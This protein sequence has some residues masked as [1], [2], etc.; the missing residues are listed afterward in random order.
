ML[1][2]VS[3]PHVYNVS[4]TKK[5]SLPHLTSHILFDMHGRESQL[6]TIQNHHNTQRV[7]FHKAKM[8]NNEGI[9]SYVYS[10]DID[11]KTYIVIAQNV[12]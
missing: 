1:S 3:I 12:S 5:Y 4:S 7:N 2:S 11:A 10:V 9:A 8:N 6:I